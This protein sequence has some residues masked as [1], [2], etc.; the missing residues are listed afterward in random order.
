MLSSQDSEN[1]QSS[2]ILEYKQLNV[3]EFQSKMLKMLGLVVLIVGCVRAASLP[4]EKV[5]AL[6][7][8]QA[9]TSDRGT[10]PVRFSRSGTSLRFP[11]GKLLNAMID[12]RPLSDSEQFHDEKAK[13]LANEKVTFSDW[14]S[15]E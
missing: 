9:V 15:G 3:V 2:Y 7:S 13:T 14:F 11:N 5:S 4:S 10:H 1:V 12:R 6:N 8:G